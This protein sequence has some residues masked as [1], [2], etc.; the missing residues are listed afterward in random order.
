MY[1]QVNCGCDQYPHHGPGPLWNYGHC[2]CGH[3]MPHRR[4]PTKQ[5]IKE[6]LTEY[7]LQL[8]AEVEGIEEK[9]A[10]LETEN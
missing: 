2:C 4:F 10:D 1:H 8:R 7:L 6:E 9:L 3:N 5:E